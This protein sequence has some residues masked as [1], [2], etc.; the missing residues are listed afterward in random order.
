MAIALIAAILSS[1][2]LIGCGKGGSG[3]TDEKEYDVTI[4]V[5]SST[6]EE[7]IFTPDIDRIHYEYEYDGVERTFRVLEYNLP[8]HPKWKDKWFGPGGALCFYSEICRREDGDWKKV[9]SIC[10]RGE[11]LYYINVDAASNLGKFRAAR[12]LITIK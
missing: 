5:V 2:F 10:D 8:E 7:W 12:L 9:K 1:C 6:D 3:E 11:Y 4:K